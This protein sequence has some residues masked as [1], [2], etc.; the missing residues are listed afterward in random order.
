MVRHHLQPYSEAM[1]PPTGYHQRSNVNNYVR[2]VLYFYSVF[3]LGG[4]LNCVISFFCTWVT[5]AAPE[6]SET[7]SA[8]MQA[9]L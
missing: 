2:F 3:V 7:H 4:M 6:Q 1:L 5:V 9:I 8:P